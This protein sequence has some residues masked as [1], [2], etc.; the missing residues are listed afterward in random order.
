MIIARCPACQT[1]FRARPEQLSAHGGRVRCGHCLTPFNALDNLVVDAQAQAS[2]DINDQTDFDEPTAHTEPPQTPL[3]NTLHGPRLPDPEAFFL[4]QD[5]PPDASTRPSLSPWVP[6]DKPA[7]T[8]APQRLNTWPGL[9]TTDDAAQTDGEKHPSTFERMADRLDFVVPDEFL[10][11]RPIE[12]EESASCTDG[13]ASWS[14]EVA[15]EFSRMEGTSRVEFP[16]NASTEASITQKTDANIAPHCDTAAPTLDSLGSAVIRR[17]TPQLAETV[18]TEPPVS[19]A[20]DAGQDETSS[21]GRYGD[22]QASSGRRWFMGL[23]IGILLGTLSAQ[24][25]YNFR[26]EITRH[27]PQLRPLYL[28]L[29]AQLGCELP[30]PRVAAAIRITSSNLE[31]DPAEPTHF[32]LNAS[33]VNQARHPLAF[34]HLELTLTDARDRSIVRRVLGPEEWARNADTSK[35]M[36]AGE[37]VEISLAFSAPDLTDATGYRVYAFYP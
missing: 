19:G 13:Q 23:V 8:E 2:P 29:C 3:S 4:L 10:P 36:A 37:E 24:I 31:S 16:A 22:P 27:W 7:A 9:T 26:V 17:R 18:A 12:R 30:L 14:D 33:I 25:A 6:E 5:P 1:V 32:V 11:S 20:L 15:G 34:P 35:G 28:E 21:S